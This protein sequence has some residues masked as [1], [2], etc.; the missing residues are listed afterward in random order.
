MAPERGRSP[1]RN[2]HGRP[3][4]E[5]SPDSVDG[6]RSR[7]GGYTEV[8]V[9]VPSQRRGRTPLA[10]VFESS[11]DKSPSTGRRS[12]EQVN[13]HSQNGHGVKRRTTLPPEEYEITTL[14]ISKAKQSLGEYNTQ[15]NTKTHVFKLMCAVSDIHYI[16]SRGHGLLVM[17][18]NSLLTDAKSKDDIHILTLFN[19]LDLLL[20]AI[21]H[22]SCFPCI[23]TGISISGGMESRVQPMIKIEKIFPGGAASTNE[24]LKVETLQCNLKNLISSP[25]V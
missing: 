8:S 21:P 24:A 9:H 4:R 16:T 15:Y 18:S 10:D 13:G 17:E 7:Q 25:E 5:A 3:R 2:G 1:V 23:L 19:L 20:F 6:R 11:R 22:V 14:T 12:S